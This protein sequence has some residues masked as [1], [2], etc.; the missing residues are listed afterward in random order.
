VVKR[1]AGDGTF[2]APPGEPFNYLS[3]Q[4]EALTLADFNGDGRDDVALPIASS[5][6]ELADHS[7]WIFESD[8][9]GSLA[10]AS[11]DPYSVAPATA[12]MKIGSGDFNGDGRTD[13]VTGNGSDDLTVLL[14]TDPSQ[15]K[16]VVEPTEIDFGHQFAGAGPGGGQF[17]DL[18][19]TG[20]A[21]LEVGSVEIAGADADQFELSTD[22]CSATT[23]ATGE[24]CEM[25]VNFH[26]TTT[27]AKS[28]TLTVPSNAP[29]SPTV[30]TL[31]GTG[32]PNSGILVE[33]TAFD[34]GTQLAGT[35]PGTPFVFTV[36][37]AG[38]TSLNVGSVEL[39]GLYPDQFELLFDGC[40]GEAVDPGDS[41]EIEVAFDPQE[42][43]P[44]SATLIV[45][46]DAPDSP[47]FVGLTGFGEPNPD[48]ALSPTS[49]DFLDVQ[50]G[51]WSAP[52]IFTV[53]STGTTGLT[54]LSVEIEGANPE[55]FEIETDGC[56]GEE[57][58]PGGLCQIEVAFGPASVGA[59]SASLEVFSDSPRSPVT[60]ALSGTGTG[61][62]GISLSPTSDDFGNQ[63]AG[64]GP[65]ASQFF[66]VEST[67]TTPLNLATLA[68]AGSDPDEFAMNHDECSGRQLEPEETC[69]VEVAFDPVS[70]GT[71]SA[72]LS[73]PS[74]APGSPVTASLAGTGL[75]NAAA[76][77]SPGLYDFGG[78]AVGSGSPAHAFT[79]ESTGTT[80]LNLSGVGFGGSN[81]DQFQYLAEDCPATLNPG[82]SCQFGVFFEPTSVGAK[83]A[84]LEI[85]SD[86]AASPTT[87]PLDGTGLPN[88]GLTI[89]PTS[90]DFGNLAVGDEGVSQQAFTLESSGMTPVTIG[91]LHVAGSDAGDFIIVEEDCFSQQLAPQETCEVE[92]DFEPS[93]VGTRAAT[94]N[95]GSDAPGTPTS[96]TL[97]GT[98]TANPGIAVEP[99]SLDFGS[100]TVGGDAVETKLVTVESSG[101]TTLNLGTATLSGA[102]N[103]QFVVG[104]GCDGESLSPETSC[105]VSVG[106]LPTAVGPKSATLEIPSDAP[107][108]PATVTLSGTATPK[109]DSGGA[110]VTPPPAPAC[111]PAEVTKL[112]PYQPKS[113]QTPS[114][115]GVRVRFTTGGPAIVEA[116]AS[117]S[118]K[119]NG[120]ARSASL[121]R[122]Q[123]NVRGSFANYKVAI[124]SNL[125]NLL[126]PGTRVTLK[127][128]YRTKS[129]DSSCSGFGPARAKSL[130]T[131]VVWIVR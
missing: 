5:I 56:S 51:S 2:T 61:N 25:V 3:N 113:K 23:L 40:S 31:A 58:D 66:T 28:A 109:P 131:R 14:N 76:S 83:S 91:S 49:H 35:G 18:T 55:Q 8:P 114:T 75:A 81:A 46:S 101:T 97:S 57:I 89:S 24:G 60:A 6:G 104:G 95:I 105:Q 73:V 106:F 94:L 74:D 112:A 26:P 17:F 115:T 30:A 128:R 64:E 108:S 117:I 123:L 71:K 124:P 67:G 36:V 120:R 42:A 47:T 59:K 70:A 102:D 9:N 11:G 34:F 44:A 87:A 125:E 121:G 12:P 118:F 38:T 90:H 127:L 54:V 77:L 99:G 116:G 22:L 4:T 19:S 41:C 92:V 126:P 20:P 96:A 32:D 130:H 7:V 93:A 103:S 15:P 43:G 98:G 39:G 10:A 84:L 82:Q 80:P 68:L 33:P 78:V 79:L 52:Q 45:P 86:A 122:S 72:A 37:S 100:H 29:G 16:L 88:P 110:N 21:P 65:G 119:V 62:P 107:G 13:V 111:P 27:G 69:T 1:G 129:P 53:E 85:S 63:L 48:Q 50:V